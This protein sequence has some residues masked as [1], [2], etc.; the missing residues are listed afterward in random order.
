MAHQLNRK[1]RVTLEAIFTHPA[2]SDIRWADIEAL[3]R[4]LGADKDERAG[5]RV[6]FF[7]NGRKALFHKPH[8]DRVAGKGLVQSV[9]RFLI[10]AEVEP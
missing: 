5:S 2:P 8:P 6:A 9:R 7:L 3:L 10:E 1:R 4:A